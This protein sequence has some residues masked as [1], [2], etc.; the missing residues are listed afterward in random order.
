MKTFLAT[1]SA[2]LRMLLRNRTLLITS[3]GLALISI[4]VF[5]WLFGSGNDP[6]LRLGIVDHDNSATS[7][8]IVTQLGASDSLK[9]STG[10]GDEELAAL[11]SGE[12][13]AVIV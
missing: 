5:G 13:D 2:Q 4:F 10:G 11:R 12:R 3:L 9:V 8:Q 7:K 6:Q 1:L